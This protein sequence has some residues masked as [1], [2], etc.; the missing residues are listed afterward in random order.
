MRRMNNDDS[1]RDGL[2]PP[3][4]DMSAEEFRR[5]GHALPEFHRGGCVTESETKNH[6]YYRGVTNHRLTT[7]SRK[8]PA[9]AHAA[10]RADM[11]RHCS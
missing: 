7:A 4:G 8:Q 5:H 3:T 9:A 10:R 2:A 11:P 6:E 1:E